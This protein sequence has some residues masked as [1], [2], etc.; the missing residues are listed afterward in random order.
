ME[1]NAQ[2]LELLRARIQTLPDH[3]KNKIYAQIEELTRR[4]T[5]EKAREDLLEF[6]MQT[7]PN[8]MVGPHHKIIA[9][10]FEAI[11]RG[12]K[13]RVIINIAPRHGKSV[14]SSTLLPAWFMGKFPNKKIIMGSHT[15]DLAVDFGRKVRDMIAEPSY[16]TIF[17]DV[18]LKADAK[19]AGRWSTNKGGEYYAVGVGGALAGRGADLF[20]IDDPHSEQEAMSG[21]QAVFTNAWEWFQSGPLQR[22]MPGGAIVILMTRW[23]KLDLTG[24]LIN[25]MTKNPDADQ[26]EV[27]EFPAILPSGKSLW[28]EFWPVEQLLAKKAGMSPWYWDAQYMQN[29][30]TREGALIKA[31]WWQPWEK[32]DPPDCNYIIMSLDAAQEAHNRADYSAVTIWG[33][34]ERSDHV[35]GNT[36]TNIV[37]L[38]AW[39]DRMEFPEL[40]R[41]MLA[42]YKEW[43]P[44]T[45]IVEKK[46]AGAQLYQEFRSM[47]M[48]VTEFTP[49][50]G[51]D[52]IARVNSISDMFASGIV[53][54]PKDR[55]WAQEVIQECQEFP[56]GEHD[57]FVDSVSQALIRIRKG[58]MI[59]LPSDYEDDERGYRAPRKLYNF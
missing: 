7:F 54:A 25:H 30:T 10:V 41:T 46:S 42:Q 31:E 28:P 52:K 40:K 43:E 33:V 34:F 17:P 11:A 37:L 36:V 27:I 16:K 15:A 12:E 47:G 45:F 39:K 14:L 51:N 21:N 26:W 20:I 18:E 57:D 59:R 22:L 50:K 55:R 38:N 2:N 4:K 44:D 23:S 56:A 5:A 13:K 8:F 35:T 6:G 58:G 9:E 29:P 3:Q 49:S 48:P 1:L 19:A 53:W 24:Q 32:E